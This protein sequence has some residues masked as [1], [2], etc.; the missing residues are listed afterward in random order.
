MSPEQA[1]QFQQ[2]SDDCLRLAG[3]TVDLQEQS[4]WLVPNQAL[5]PAVARCVDAGNSGPPTSSLEPT[6]HESVSRE[7][8]GGDGA[9]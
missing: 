8:E 3:E 5:P 1:K 9:E 7:P 2:R 4:L 6:A